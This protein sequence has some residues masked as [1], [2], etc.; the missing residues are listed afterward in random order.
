MFQPLCVPWDAPEWCYL[1]TLT[2]ANPEPSYAEARRRFKNFQ[3]YLERNRWCAV[4]VPQY[5]DRTHRLHFHL[6]LNRR[7]DI[8]I[9]RSVLQRYGF[10]NPDVKKRP[11]WRARGLIPHPCIWYA[12]RYVARGGWWSPEA[13]GSRRWSV[14]GEKFGPPDGWVVHTREIK[15]RVG[16]CVLVA[17]SPHLPASSEFT[18]ADWNNRTM[19]VR[20]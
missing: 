12:A 19:S 6:I 15:V 4:V 1:L 11:A 2:F 8:K 14:I 20:L 13:K 5:G 3:K 18:F 17:V 10:G 7:P 9:W 16:A